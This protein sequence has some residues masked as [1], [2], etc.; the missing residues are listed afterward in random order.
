MTENDT[1]TESEELAKDKGI[2]SK[3]NIR[4]VLPVI[5]F[6]LILAFFAFAPC[7]RIVQP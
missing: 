6:V 1:I 3:I 7:G 4:S 5:G 2:L